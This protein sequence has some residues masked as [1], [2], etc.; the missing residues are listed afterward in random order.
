[1]G[2]FSWVRSGDLNREGKIFMIVWIRIFEY[3]GSTRGKGFGGHS[4][5]GQSPR[6]EW[7]HGK[8]RAVFRVPMQIL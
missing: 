2:N 8:R 7:S 6:L 5:F 3:F 4:A 1:M